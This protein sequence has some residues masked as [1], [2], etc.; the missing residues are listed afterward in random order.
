ML[1]NDIETLN[2]Y[3]S[4]CSWIHG[5]GPIAELATQYKS[6]S[7]LEIGVAYGYHAAHLITVCHGIKYTGV[8]P[9]RAGYD[10]GDSLAADVAQLF[11]YK[12]TEV[13]Q[14][15]LAMDR[16]HDAVRFSL[17]EIDPDARLIRGDFLNFSVEY[18]S[19][20]FDLV[21]IDGDH[22]EDGVFSDVIHAL[23]HVNQGGILCGDDIEWTSVQA[24]L[25]RASKYYRLN[26][27]LYKSAK[28]GKVVWVIEC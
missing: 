11:G 18:P 2:N 6:R 7:I 14:Q 10:P 22:T 1:N 26:P 4:Q 20:K 21:Y 16:L 12:R 25:S 24:G 9:Y 5:Y 28:T 13:G 3:R 15:Q 23:K 17:K 27:K 8:D 19:E